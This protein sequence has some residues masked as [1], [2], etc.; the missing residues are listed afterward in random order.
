[1]DW[2]ND[3]DEEKIGKSILKTAG[4]NLVIGL[5]SVR[6][7]SNKTGVIQNYRNYQFHSTLVEADKKTNEL[8]VES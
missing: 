8:N 5:I 4:Y 3:Y 2:L 6:A 1:M 7:S